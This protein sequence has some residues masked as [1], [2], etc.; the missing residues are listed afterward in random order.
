LGGL[1][2][3]ID[4]VL[5]KIGHGEGLTGSGSEMVEALH[6]IRIHAQHVH[7]RLGEIRPC[8]RDGHALLGERRN[9]GNALL[10]RET[11]PYFIRQLRVEVS[12]PSL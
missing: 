9:S 1:R 4:F 12:L 6:G 7:P 11:V 2:A 10:V 8:R 5:P 3:E